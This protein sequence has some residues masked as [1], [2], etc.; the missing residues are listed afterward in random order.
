MGGQ[1]VEWVEVMKTLEGFVL[2]QARGH[3]SIG[4]IGLELRREGR[5][6]LTDFRLSAQ[7]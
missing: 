7:R 2:T 4:Y 3:L 5:T 1:S 6:D